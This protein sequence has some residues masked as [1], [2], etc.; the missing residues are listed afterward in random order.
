ML[1]RQKGHGKKPAEI[2]FPLDCVTEK[3][4]LPRLL[5]ALEA[6]DWS[7]DQDGDPNND[8]RDIDSDF[9]SFLDTIE[10]SE[11][12]LGNSKSGVTLSQEPNVRAS[13]LEEQQTS[14]IE[15]DEHGEGEGEG[16]ESQ[17]QELEAMVLKMQAVKG[18]RRSTILF[19]PSSFSLSPNGTLCHKPVQ[20]L[21]CGDDY[22]RIFLHFKIVFYKGSADF[23]LFSFFSQIEMSRDM[24]EAERRRLAARA[25][26]GILRGVSEV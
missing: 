25:V 15:Q 22:V 18:K 2:V 11:A 4:G 5:E 23:F 7:P 10:E 14:Q 3:T 16:E 20:G 6:N 1:K 17:V 12:G 24:P 21:I 26:R 9:D 13:L 8:D 19:F